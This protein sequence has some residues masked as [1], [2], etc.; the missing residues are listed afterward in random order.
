MLIELN[1]LCT[2]AFKI[3]KEKGFWNSN[4]FSENLIIQKAFRSQKLA[5]IHS[6]VSE[7]LIAD[8]K[9]E[10]QFNTVEKELADIII[11]VFDFCGAY[12]IDIEKEIFEKME[13]NRHRPNM[14]GNNFF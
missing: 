8:R 1:E 6:E 9:I 7:T 4:H 13:F 11:R 12:N 5:L 3:A 2:E 10:K 14:N